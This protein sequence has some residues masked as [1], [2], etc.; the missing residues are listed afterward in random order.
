MQKRN[1]D[2]G[3]REQL[4]KIQQNRGQRSRVV[5]VGT[6]V[7]LLAQ[8]IRDRSFGPASEVASILASV[9]DDEFRR[10]CRVAVV[11][12]G[13]VEFSV[14]RGDLVWAMRMR[15]A[16]RLAEGLAA[17]RSSGAIKG[18]TF[19]FGRGGIELKAPAQA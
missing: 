13:R 18:V 3:S 15:W 2:R 14:D 11:Q 19:R 7:Q 12:A 4:I 10:H 8:R 16:E 9:V 6:R 5:S 17:R 1:R